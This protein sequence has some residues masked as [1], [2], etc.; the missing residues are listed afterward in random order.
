M[1]FII[2]RSSFIKALQKIQGIVEKR[3]TMP[4]LANV[5]LDAGDGKITIVAT[6]LEV[7]IKDSSKAETTEAGSVTI[8]ARK[9]FEIIKELPDDTVD[10]SA[11]KNDRVTIKAGKA[12]FSIMGLP[13]RDFPVFPEIDESKLEKI[14]SESLKEMIDKTSFAVSTDETRYNINGFLF[15]KE[16]TRIR[17]VATDGHRLAF[18]EKKDAGG[19]PTDQKE[20]VLL[21]RKGVLEM[22]K[23]LENEGEFV[24]GVT[25]KSAVMKKDDAV[26]S[27]RLLEGEFPD[28]EKV[29]PKDNNKEVVAGREALLASLKRVSLLSSDK[30]KGVK[31]SFSKS[32]L[33]VSSSSPDIG[34]ATEDVDIDYGEEDIEIAFNARY[35]I[36]MLEAVGEEQVKILLKDSLSP[37]IIRPVDTENYTYIIMPMRL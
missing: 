5:L 4:I 26:I 17:M 23:L 13:S 7:F 6:D 31:F 9:L 30:I 19:K 28:Y 27:V 34:E 29:I 1:R 10:V 35:F 32:C 15:E 21:P 3:N 18:I 8:N 33:T 14:D 11:D 24:L 36:D 12:R 25:Q 2:D 16:D 20:G 37:G 22:R